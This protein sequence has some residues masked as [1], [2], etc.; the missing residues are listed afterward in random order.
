LLSLI[1]IFSGT[2]VYYDDEPWIDTST[3]FSK[4]REQELIKNPAYV[5]RLGE[6]LQVLR[7]TV[8]RYPLDQIALSFNGGKD[9]TV[10]LHLF[11]LVVDEMFGPEVEIQGFHIVCDDHFPETTQFIIDAARNYNMVMSEYPGPLKAGLKL[12]KKEQPNVV[13]VL[14]GS[15]ASDPRGNRMRLVLFFYLSHI[16]WTD[17]DWPK[18]LR[19]CPVLLWSYHDVWSLLRG[20]CVPYCSL[21][22]MGYTSLGGRTTTVKNPLLKIVEKDGVER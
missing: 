18:I 9:C 1:K 4:Y 14:L 2:L 15:R 16:E 22:D 5:L 6:A 21:Y 17:E 19:V 11:R 10:L 13:A 20:L 7:R 3:K 8:E 12:M